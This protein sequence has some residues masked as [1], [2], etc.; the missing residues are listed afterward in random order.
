MVHLISGGVDRWA[1]TKFGN[2]KAHVTRNSE[3]AV[4]RIV[5]IRDRFRLCAAVG[6]TG[7]QIGNISDPALILCRP[8]Q[9][10]VVVRFVHR[11]TNLLSAMPFGVTY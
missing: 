2:R 8:E 1:V 10:D 4:D 5:D 9:I 6:R 3:P 7:L 11:I